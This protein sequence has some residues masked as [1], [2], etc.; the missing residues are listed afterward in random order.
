MQ[1]SLRSRL[2][3]RKPGL[4]QLLDLVCARPLLKNPE[5]PGHAPSFFPFG[6]LHSQDAGVTSAVELAFFSVQALLLSDSPR[7]EDSFNLPV[8]R[9]PRKVA[10]PQFKVRERKSRHESALRRLWRRAASPFPTFTSACST[11]AVSTHQ[12]YGRCSLV[13]ERKL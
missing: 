1:I 9:N 12:T 3:A 8:K 5:G 7:S 6:F 4:R 11:P 10:A 2:L 13:A